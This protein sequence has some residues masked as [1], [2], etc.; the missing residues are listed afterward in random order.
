MH[1]R[2]LKHQYATIHF[3]LIEAIDTQLNLAHRVSTRLQHHQRCPSPL[4]NDSAVGRGQYKR[5]QLVIES[6]SP[7]PSALAYHSRMVGEAVL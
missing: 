4:S 3:G 5:Y 7:I 2:I 6:Q 1:I